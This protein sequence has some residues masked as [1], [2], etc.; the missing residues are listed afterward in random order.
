M[1]NAESASTTYDLDQ[2]TNNN[3]IIEPVENAVL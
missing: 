3:L 1:G 2:K